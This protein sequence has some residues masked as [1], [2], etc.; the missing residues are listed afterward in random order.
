MDT[1][2]KKDKNIGTV[3]TIYFTFA[4]PPGELLLESGEKLGPVTLAYET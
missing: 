2:S 4:L 1:V 3:E